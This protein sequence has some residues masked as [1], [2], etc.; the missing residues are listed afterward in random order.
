MRRLEHGQQ[1]ARAGGHSSSA[2]GRHLVAAGRCTRCRRQLRRREF[3]RSSSRSSTRPQIRRLATSSRSIRGIPTSIHLSTSDSPVR[4]RARRESRCVA[5]GTP[6]GV[7]SATNG[8]RTRLRGDVVD[9]AQLA[10]GA[11]DVRARVVERSPETRRRLRPCVAGDRCGLRSPMRAESTLAVGQSKRVKVKSARGQRPKYRVV[12]PRSPAS[13]VRQFGR[14]DR[15]ARPTRQGNPRTNEPVDVFELIDA[16]GRDW[17]HVATVR[18]ASDGPVRVSRTARPRAEAQVRLHGNVCIK[19]PIED[20]DRTSRAGRRSR[21][22]PDR[23]HRDQRQRGR[24]QREAAGRSDPGFWKATGV[25]GT[26]PA[27]VGGPSLHRGARAGRRAVA[28]SD[29]GSPPRPV[30]LTY[31][32]RVVVPAESGYPYA[33][34]NSQDPLALLY[35][36]DDQSMLKPTAPTDFPTR[37]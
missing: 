32:F 24:V 14:V 26:H 23:R 5:R 4:C 34:G 25:A 6:V 8:R 7:R 3:R 15:Q 22:K 12:L 33:Q 31:S 9:D 1:R 35:L 28:F 29:T 21:S 20:D 27:G 19:R 13:F 10:A 30:K 2:S 17:R 11:Y 18:T 36:Q 16:P 37:T